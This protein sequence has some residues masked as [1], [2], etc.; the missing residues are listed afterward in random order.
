[1]ALS[2]TAGSVFMMPEAVRPDHPHAVRPRLRDQRPLGL[3]DLSPRSL[4]PP[5]MMTSPRTRLRAH[6]VDHAGTAAAGIASTARSTSSGY[7]VDA[8]IGPHAGDEL[9]VRVDGIDRTLEAGAQQVDQHDCDRRFAGPGWHRPRRPNEG[10]AAARPSGP[11][12]GARA[13]A[14][15]R[16]RRRSA[17]SRRPGGS[18][19]PRRSWSPDSPRRRTPAP[20][21]SCR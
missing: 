1:M 6:C 10:R 3:P 20:S 4:N 21:G 8:L 11:P 18:R 19:P 17:R 5:D 12:P 16:S 14:S 9:R 13:T 2:S 7:V 15:P